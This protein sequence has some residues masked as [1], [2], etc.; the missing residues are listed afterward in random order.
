MNIIITE[1][2]TRLNYIIEKTHS[3]GIYIKQLIAV[4]GRKSDKKA[5]V[6]FSKF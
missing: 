6:Y 1:V 3:V 5:R 4:D 2:Y